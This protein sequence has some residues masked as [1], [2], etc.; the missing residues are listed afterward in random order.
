MNH[1][2]VTIAATY[3][4]PKHKITLIQYEEFFNSLNH[5]FTIS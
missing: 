2:P 3:F 5:Y 1:I 4:P